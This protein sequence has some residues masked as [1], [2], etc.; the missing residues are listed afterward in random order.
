MACFLALLSAL[1]YFLSIQYN[2]PS[3][4]TG[5]IVVS[6]VM[7]IISYWFSD[8]IVLRLSNAKQVG[9]TE[10]PIFWKVTEN[11]AR[12]AGLPM[13]K[14][15]V[16]NDPALN[17]FATGRNKDHAVVAVTTGLVSALDESEL[18]GVVAHELS[19]IGN[20]D[21]LLMSVVAVL[22]GCISL[23]ADSAMRSSLFRSRDDDRGGQILMM[24]GLVFIIISPIAAAIIQL[25]ISRKREFLADASA[26]ILTH[27]PQ[28][29]ANAL[30]KISSHQRPL[31]K[32]H[33]ATAHLFISNPL[34]GESRTP[35]FAKL[36][37]THPPIQERIDAL[38]SRRSS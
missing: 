17:A 15:Y 8:K 21:I 5:F 29:L 18:E 16:I 2:N 12:K 13:P 19:H 24:V 27:K 3:I 34:K 38:L 1:G 31:L 20:R 11:L 28:G 4:F 32:A 23:A 22:V 30:L 26:A 14:L 25:A 6:I 7:N 33:T 36:F 9:R 35:G 10:F 37:M